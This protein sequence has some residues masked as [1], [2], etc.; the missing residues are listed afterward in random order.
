[1]SKRWP[2]TIYRG[3]VRE[4]VSILLTPEGHR[5]LAALVEGMA[6]SRSDLTERLYRLAYAKPQILELDEEPA[7]E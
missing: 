1:M 6:I 7:D 2:D 5:C 4:P 3:K